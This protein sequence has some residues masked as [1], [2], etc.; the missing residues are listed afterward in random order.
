VGIRAHCLLLKLK[1]KLNAAWKSGR[2]RRSQSEQIWLEDTVNQ[3][4]DELAVQMGEFRR[5]LEAL[6]P[7]PPAPAPAAAPDRGVSAVLELE[8]AVDRA[9]AIL[10]MVVCKA[11][12]EDRKGRVH[13]EEPTWLSHLQLVAYHTTDDLR[14]TFARSLAKARG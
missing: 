7:R 3:V 4:A 14:G 1:G 6:A 8:D 13:Y 11:R 9:C 2:R 10:D 5:Q 12:D